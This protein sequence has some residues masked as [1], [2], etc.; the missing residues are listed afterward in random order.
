MNS[1]EQS[2]I[3]LERWRRASL[4]TARFNR[5]MP[6]TLQGLGLL[7]CELLVRDSQLVTNQTPFQIDENPMYLARHLTLSYLWILGAYEIVRS[8]AQQMRINSKQEIAE[9]STFSMLLRTF[10]RLRIPLAKFEASNRTARTD[11]PIAYPALD[12]MTGIS[13]EVASDVYISRTSLSDELLDYLD[14]SNTPPEGT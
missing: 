14:R 11:F 6:A 8:M 5:N 9:G 12:P 3:R 13:W 1:P 7:D 10:E 2:A 4:S